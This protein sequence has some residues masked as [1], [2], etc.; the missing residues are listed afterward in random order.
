MKDFGYLIENFFT[1]KDFLAP[2]HELP[3]TMFTPLHFVFAGIVLAIVIVAAIVVGR[4]EKAIKP[5][6]IAVWV[7]VV[8][9]EIAKIIWESVSGRQIG[10]EW[11]GILPL[12]P[13][14]LYM[15]AMPFAIWGK[16]N[17]KKA[18]CGYV[19]TVGLLGGCINFF[20]P[21]TVLPTY[22]CISFA[23][24]HTFILS[25]CDAFYLS[26]HADLRLSPLYWGGKVAA[27][28]PGGHPG[29]DP[30]RACQPRQLHC[31]GGLYVLQGRQRLPAGDL[32][33]RVR[34]G[35]HGDHLSALH[36]RAGDVLSAL[37]FGEQKEA[38]RGEVKNMKDLSGGLLR[39]SGIAKMGKR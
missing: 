6:F 4:K 16:G 11:T 36:L 2:A 38:S 30:V 24:M 32:W 37:V 20:Y 22:S 18:A 35:Y 8:V 15:Y 26:C 23:G 10:I 14:S 19:C 31:G 33:R 12:Y 5:V 21:M 25:R 9:L 3:G 17:V 28:V 29:P 27:D 39:L 1:H 7:T 13:C 34:P